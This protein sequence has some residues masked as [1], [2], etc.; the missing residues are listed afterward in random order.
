MRNPS[1]FKCICPEGW[2]GIDC[3]ENLD[4]CEYS[5]CQN[6]GACKDRI[7]GYVCECSHGFSGD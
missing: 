4:D 3:S 1:G 2:G 6:G 7:G 5:K